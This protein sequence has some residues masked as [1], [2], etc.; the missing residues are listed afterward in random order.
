MQIV[1]S[2]GSGFRDPASAIRHMKI[3]FVGVGEAFDETL[4][5]NSQV[6]EWNEYRLLVDC[7]YAVPHALWKRHPDPEYLDA[8]YISHPHADHYFGLPSYLI[9]LAEDGRKRKI[10]VFCPSGVKTTISEMIECGYRGILSKIPLTLTIRE[11]KLGEPLE[12]AGGRVEFAQSAH[13]VRNYAIAVSHGA[14]KYA[15]SGDG[16]YTPETFD[17]YRNA[18]LLAHEAYCLGPPFHGH[19]SIS[20]VIAMAERAE[21]ETLALTHLQR[22]TRRNNRAEINALIAGSRIKVIIPEPGDVFEI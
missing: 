14:G 15:Y 7:G 13:P 6:L 2:S 19:A 17:L 1:D 8:V 22:D 3:E 5:N 18:K 20:E 9:R 11:V 12:L 10:E 21:V 4:P 16:N